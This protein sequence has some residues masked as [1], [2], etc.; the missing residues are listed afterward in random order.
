MSQ[1]GWERLKSSIARLLKE[2]HQ[3]HPLRLGMPREELRNRLGISPA[4]FPQMLPALAEE[5]VLVEAGAL[6]R[7]PDHQVRLTPDQER[8]AKAYVEALKAEPFSPPTD[9]P[10]DA[11]LLV[12]LADQGRVVRVSDTVVLAA[13]AYA[14]MVERVVGR[15]RGQGKI[16]VGDVRDMFG[17]SRKY[18]LALL[19]HLDQQRITRRVGDERVLLRE[20]ESH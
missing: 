19:E 3:H 4:V 8:A 9:R 11:R 10:I 7:S 20:P 5:G 1:T 18:A 13:R 6:V 14:E 15:L 17:T 16:T 12:A 2:Y